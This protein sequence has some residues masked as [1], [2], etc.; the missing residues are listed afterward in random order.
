MVR[1][2]AVK[3]LIEGNTVLTEATLRLD[4]LFGEDL[5]ISEADFANA[6]AIG[7]NAVG[8]RDAEVGKDG[9]RTLVTV[10]TTED[11]IV[12]SVLEN[13]V[14]DIRKRAGS[15]FA[16]PVGRAA[17]EPERVVVSTVVKG[18]AGLPRPLRSSRPIVRVQVTGEVPDDARKIEARAREELGM[19]VDVNRAPA[20][21]AFRVEDDSVEMADA[22]VMRDIVAEFQDSVREPT[23]VYLA[24]ESDLTL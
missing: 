17:A 2:R 20:G 8:I 6:R 22:L 11:E 3:P 5:P 12:Q 13:A 21:F 16:S 1:P 10:F 18:R 19:R 14:F 15:D 7:N 24:T 23:L 4:V 9:Q